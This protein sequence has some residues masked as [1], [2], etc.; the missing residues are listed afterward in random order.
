MST[1]DLYSQEEPVMEVEAAPIVKVSSTGTVQL[2]NKMPVG[3]DITLL[4]GTNLSLGPNVKGLS[5]NISRP[6]L[7]KLLPSYIN[8]LISKGEL[9]KINC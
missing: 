8:R 1:F 9:K 7:R 6:I 4:D 5:V 2:I 3:I